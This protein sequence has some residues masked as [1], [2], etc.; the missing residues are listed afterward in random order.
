MCG[1]LEVCVLLGGAV[2]SKGQMPVE[3][4]ETTH[5]EAKRDSKTECKKVTDTLSDRMMTLPLVE[6]ECKRK[7]NL[8]LKLPERLLLLFSS[9]PPL[10][11]IIHFNPNSKQPILTACMQVSWKRAA[12]Y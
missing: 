12:F 9:P 3:H 11:F 6:F 5:S 7:E 4:G 8:S 10:V 1:H 2:F